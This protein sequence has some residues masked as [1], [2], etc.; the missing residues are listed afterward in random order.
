M[1]LKF[2]ITAVWDL[3]AHTSYKCLW[4]TR[5]I[6]SHFQYCREGIHKDL[7]SDVAQHVWHNKRTKTP[8][9]ITCKAEYLRSVNLKKLPTPWHGYQNLLKMSKDTR[10]LK[11]AT[12]MP[13]RNY[14]YKKELWQFVLLQI[15][16][17]DLAHH[18]RISKAV[19]MTRV[20]W[21]GITAFNAVSRMKG[22]SYNTQEPLN[23]QFYRKTKDTYQ[24]RL[25][26]T[27]L[28]NCDNAT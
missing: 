15:I 21:C 14:S 18:S 5:A 19:N 16:K 27:S 23:M 22:E 2:Y 28:V 17:C 1:H 24:L 7:I 26:H 13:A 9:L 10:T 4:K 12:A 6:L 20:T 25:W 11:V 8:T 3:L